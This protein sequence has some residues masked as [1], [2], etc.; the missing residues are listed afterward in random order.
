MTLSKPVIGIIGGIGSGKSLVAAELAKQGGKVIAGDQLGHEALRQPDIKAK[1][2]Q[3]WPQV[4]D[5]DGK[6]D[7]REL[8]AIVFADA[9]ERRALEAFVHPYIER[10][11]TEEVRRGR[12]DT[13]ISLMALDA[14][15]LLHRQ[16]ERVGA[17]LPAFT[18]RDERR[19][20][21]LWVGVLPS[22]ARLRLAR[23]PSWQVDG[24]SVI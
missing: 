16:L 2:A 10:R 3:R 18:E 14:A 20:T 24:S 8:G 17:G 9:A 22:R 1:I 7:R 6:V 12:A 21:E 4:I 15:V 11:I 13:R 19:T 23:N 5:A